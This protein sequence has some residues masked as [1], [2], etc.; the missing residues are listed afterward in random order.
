[1]DTWIAL[2]SALVAVAALAV[3][4]TTHRVEGRALVISHEQQLWSLFDRIHQGL[5]E[6]GADRL[7][8]A[9][10][11][12]E[13]DPAQVEAVYRLALQAENLAVGARIELDWL[14][15]MNLALAF[16][17]TLDPRRAARYWNS[18]QADADRGVIAGEPLVRLK[19]ALAHF[20]C[21]RGSPDDTTRYREALADAIRVSSHEAS[22]L[23]TDFGRDKHAQLVVYA[24]RLELLAGD[25]SKAVTRLVEACRISTAITSGLVRANALGGIGGFV[26][27]HPDGERLAS[28]V[29]AGLAEQR[30]PAGA[31]A[32][33]ESFRAAAAQRAATRPLPN[34]QPPH[35]R[36]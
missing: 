13:H 11:A 22:G 15:R 6:G 33:A 23:G 17:N 28:L 5:V 4:F 2:G 24:A 34:R 8:W 25:D 21:R 1:M 31:A 12:A 10:A 36:S 19:G 27:T 9:H 26:A 35:P 3:A 30:D 14:Q 29:A 18:L 32:F 7:P 16:S 20:Y